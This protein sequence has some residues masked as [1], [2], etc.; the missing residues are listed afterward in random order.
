[1]VRFPAPWRADRVPGGYVVRDANGRALDH[2]HHGPIGRIIQH[3][4]GNVPKV[5]PTPCFLPTG[6]TEGAAHVT[7][8]VNILNFVRAHGPNEVTIATSV[9]SRPRAIRMRPTRG[10]LWRASRVYQRSPR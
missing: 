8:S 6:Q 4:V 10:L 3:G 2:F 5:T 7:S 9:A 1:V